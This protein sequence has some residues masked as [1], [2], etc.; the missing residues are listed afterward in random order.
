MRLL[1]VISLAWSSGCSEKVVVERC[2]VPVVRANQC[3]KDNLKEIN[4]APCTLDYLDLVGKQQ[5]AIKAING[6]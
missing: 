1:A 4:L 6:D 2:D 5:R 3:V